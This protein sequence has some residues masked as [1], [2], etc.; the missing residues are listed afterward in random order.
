MSLDNYDPAQLIQTSY[1]KTYEQDIEYLWGSLVEL[2]TNMFI[3]E[4][5][6]K[7]PFHL[8]NLEYTLFWKILK[9][10]LYEICTLLTAKL[11]TDRDY[12][13]LTLQKFKDNVR[14]HFAKDE[15]RDLLD[16]ELKYIGL[17]KVISGF[18]NRIDT[19]RNRKIAHHDKDWLQNQTVPMLNEI[20]LNFSELQSICLKINQYFY[21]LCFSVKYSVEYVEY[22]T[23]IQHPSGTDTR[24]DIEVILDGLAFNSP[25]LNMPEQQKEFWPHQRE[26]LSKD[27]IRILNEYRNKFGLDSV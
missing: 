12:R 8:F 27:D 10:N 4:K 7:F 18:R 26:T 5:V 11:A 16:Q 23:K 13:V 19:L 14:K 20:A 24:S 15:H 2:N 25:L 3:L 9:T 6:L 17:E 22:S 21:L 1:L